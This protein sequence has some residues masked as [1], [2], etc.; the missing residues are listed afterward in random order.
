M[1]SNKTLTTAQRD[2]VPSSGFMRFNV[3]ALR[4]EFYDG[5]TWQTL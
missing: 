4:M 3:D 2:L 5:A 1:L